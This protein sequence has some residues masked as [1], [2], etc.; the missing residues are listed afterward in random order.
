MCEKPTDPTPEADFQPATPQDPQ[1]LQLPEKKEVPTGEVPRRRSRYD[2]GT[3]G[4]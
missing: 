4:R 2:S 3:F 1:H